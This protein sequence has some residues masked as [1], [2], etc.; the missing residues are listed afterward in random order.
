MRWTL[1][2]AISAVAGSTAGYC[3][4]DAPPSGSS[5]Q[6]SQIFDLPANRLVEAYFTKPVTVSTI[7][8]ADGCLTPG[9]GSPAMKGSFA[10]ET[11][12]PN[13]SAPGWSRA[14]S[15]CPDDRTRL[16]VPKSTAN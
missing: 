11:I 2:V 5:H 13:G 16:A 3:L 10:V 6:V 9:S 14:V 8:S 1:S 7:V 4:G 12:N 15:S